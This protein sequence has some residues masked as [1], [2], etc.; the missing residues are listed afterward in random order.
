MVARPPLAEYQS[1]ATYYALGWQVRP[2]G[3]DANWW[4][5]GSLPGTSTIMVR[6]ASGMAWIA[7][8]NSRPANA[9][10]FFS[11]LDTELWRAVNGIT[12]WPSVASADRAGAT[13]RRSGSQYNDNKT[14]S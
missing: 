8:F 12:E 9:D 7:L 1:S 13:F 14:N 2:T 4:H 3:G 10:A 6:T 11:E 5:T